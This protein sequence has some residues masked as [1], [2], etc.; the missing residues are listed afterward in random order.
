MVQGFQKCGWPI[1]VC[2]IVQI[3]LANAKSGFSDVWLSIMLALLSFNAL[4]IVA[5]TLLTFE[6]IPIVSAAPEVDAFPNIPFQ[7]FSHF[8]ENQFGPK[9]T[10]ATILTVMFSL[11]ENTDLLNLHAHQQHP[12][13]H[14][15]NHVSLSG[16]I[17]ALA[18]AVEEKLGNDSSTLFRA[19]EIQTHMSSDTIT[20]TLATKLDGLAKILSLHPY[21]THGRFIGKLKSVSYIDIELAF[22]IC[23]KTME[24]E[25][26]GCDAW[27]LLMGSQERDIPRVTV[28]KGSTIHQHVQVLP[29]KCPIC[30]MKYYANHEVAVQYKEDNRPPNMN[31]NKKWSKL[32]LNTAKYLRVGTRTWVNHS[33]SSMVLSGMYNFHASAAAF[34]EFWN[35]TFCSEGSQF[36]MTHCIIWQSFVQES[37]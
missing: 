19:S 18:R 23:P 24:C 22:V 5:C 26:E 30:F 9:V 2:D 13:S 15:E 16:W 33:F 27:S 32:Y 1:L 25:T 3:I 17:K 36:K 8:M 35:D 31:N 21:D 37:I 10:L 12:I 28:V 11:M 6:A 34:E 4:I 29:G 7:A 20:N 14:K